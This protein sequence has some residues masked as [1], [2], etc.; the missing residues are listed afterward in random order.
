MSSGTSNTSAEGSAHHENLEK[1]SWS[2]LWSWSSSL[3]ASDR[4][5][6]PILLSA[7]LLTA[8]SSLALSSQIK[9]GSPA[10]Q[11]GLKIGFMMASTLVHEQVRDYTQRKLLSNIYSNAITTFKKSK[12]LPEDAQASVIKHLHNV[13]QTSDTLSHNTLLMMNG[14]SAGIGSTYYIGSQL[15][16]GNYFAATLGVTMTALQAGTLYQSLDSSEN[17]KRASKK[18]TSLIKHSS[19]SPNELREVDEKIYEATSKVNSYKVISAGLESFNMLIGTKG[20]IPSLKQFLPNVGLPAALPAEWMQVSSFSKWLGASG[21]K[22][23]DFLVR[24]RDVGNSIRAIEGIF[25][26][27]SID[28]R[29]NNES[30][31][32]QKTSNDLVTPTEGQEVSNF[33][34]APWDNLGGKI[35]NFA[36]KIPSFLSLSYKNNGEVDW[37]TSTLSL[38]NIALIVSR[39]KL[40]KDLKSTS[41]GASYLYQSGGFI[42]VRMIEE[43]IT[44][45]VQNKGGLNL[46]SNIIDE[47]ELN[48]VDL[49]LPEHKKSII[50]LLSNGETVLPQSSVVTI[51]MTSGAIAT[52]DFLTSQG[53]NKVLFGY[54]L[55][56]MTS[57]I[58]GSLYYSFSFYKAKEAVIKFNS[59]FVGHGSYNENISEVLE[60]E[61]ENIIS[62]YKEI[63]LVKMLVSGTGSFNIILDEQRAVTALDSIFKLGIDKPQEALKV[64]SE[65][66]KFYGGNYYKI[67]D[68]G[69]KLGFVVEESEKINTEKE[70][71]KTI[72]DLILQDNSSLQNTNL[73]SNPAI[74]ANGVCELNEE[75][76]A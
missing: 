75:E 23:N 15:I 47:L 74:E 9:S 11:T 68:W 6:D 34:T 65:I 16:Q 57:Q 20:A 52:L 59:E 49:S 32:D 7:P 67:T 76:E 30:I 19:P 41:Y 18:L 51:S 3:F 53:G 5:Y 48:N 60:K 73:N 62:A 64:Y 21:Y 42:A 2:F 37:Q 55:S 28:I 58:L 50:K 72:M 8:F 25:D 40:L 29:S 26:I 39:F 35:L 43:L 17:L 61:L 54:F 27:H 1:S 70:P 31:D 69:T 14:L 33:F 4:F 45:K 12:E 66:I 36:S 38:L 10:L 44:G 56:S 24:G 63:S 22:F 46:R 71:V 13:A